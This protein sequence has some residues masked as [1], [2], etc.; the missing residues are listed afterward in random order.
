MRLITRR[1]AM[2]SCSLVAQIQKSITESVSATISSFAYFSKRKIATSGLVVSC[3]H[4]TVVLRVDFWLLESALDWFRYAEGDLLV[5]K[6]NSN[7]V[8][9]S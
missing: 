9:P 3:I 4:I 7:M 8:A 2:G 6:W 1:I 5:K